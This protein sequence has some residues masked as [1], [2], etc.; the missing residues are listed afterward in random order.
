MVALGCT[1]H[2]AIVA[3]INAVTLSI[4]AFQVGMYAFMAFTYFVLF[5]SPHLDAF[6]PRC[7]FMMQI[8]MICAFAAGFP[9]N[10]RLIRA[11]S[12]K[13]WNQS[14]VIPID[15]SGSS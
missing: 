11:A 4:I 10:R 7:W 15:L 14:P 12:K 6:D 3:A 8:A 9:M 1:Q 5:P 2:Q 13:L